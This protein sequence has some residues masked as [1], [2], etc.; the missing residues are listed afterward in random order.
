MNTQGGHPVS[1]SPANFT[2]GE[3]GS[4]DPLKQHAGGAEGGLFSLRWQNVQYSTM[5]NCYVSLMY[6]H[7]LTQIP[8]PHSEMSTASCKVTFLWYVRGSHSKPFEHNDW[9]TGCLMSHVFIS[10]WVLRNH[11]E[12]QLQHQIWIQ[13]FPSWSHQ[14]YVQNLLP[15]NRVCMHATQQRKQR[16]Q[17]GNFTHL[18]M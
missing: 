15:G 7:R 17:E 12:I 1:R 18:W 14:A 5:L 8:V 13:V 6:P 2:L 16:T 4:G 10:K 3:K 9:V 11:L